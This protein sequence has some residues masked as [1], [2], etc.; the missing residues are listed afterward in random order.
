[1]CQIHR[2]VSFPPRI[3][4]KSIL[5]KFTGS[6]LGIFRVYPIMSKSAKLF[7]E[8]WKIKRLKPFSANWRVSL[9]SGP[10]GSPS[11][12]FAKEDLHALRST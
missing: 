7:S 9:K 3:E 4:L 12:S 5:S 1:M 2:L 6:L 10:N 8:A 11:M